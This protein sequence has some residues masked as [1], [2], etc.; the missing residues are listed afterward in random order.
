[1]KRFCFKNRKRKSQQLLEFLLIAPFLMMVLALLTEYAYALNI[2]MT[3]REG[4]R[5]VTSSIYS[6]MRPGITQDQVRSLVQY[7][8]A[9]Y[10][11]N[12]NVPIGSTGSG[13][14]MVITNPTVGYT[15]STTSANQTSA[16]TATYTYNMAFTLPN[17]YNSSGRHSMFPNSF[18]FFTTV[19]VPS[20]FLTQNN[21][22]T[23]T[24]ITSDQLD[25]IW[26]DPGSFADLDNG[27]NAG[28]DGIMRNTDAT[29]TARNRGYILF[30]VRWNEIS[31]TLTSLKG[32]AAFP[33]VALAWDGLPYHTSDNSRYYVIDVNTP[34]GALYT[35]TKSTPY[36]CSAVTGFS[37]LS[38]VRSNKPA[39]TGYSP[40]G[41]SGNSTLIFLPNN[42]T[43]ITPASAWLSGAATT[44]DISPTNVTGLLKSAI[45]ISN[46]TGASLGNYD[47][48]DVSGYNS[49]FSTGSYV[50][51]PCGSIAIFYSSKT[52][53]Y[54]FPI[55]YIS[56]LGMTNIPDYNYE[57]SDN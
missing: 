7:N 39:S 25:R 14:S 41:T 46:S 33:Y 12:N 23:T 49:S 57:F 6:E 18:T 3:L 48:L 36:N 40:Y 20:A 26:A 5:T 45:S 4:L 24:R 52:D 30:L 19:A 55:D 47:N 44:A 37:L 43:A 27:L 17:I 21:Y 32:D 9:M 56:P 34:N 22:P 1:M 28:R 29:L 42:F 38:F 35:C 10:L 50:Y 2:N 31:T 16:F 51:R 15:Y 13:A 8:L 53:D 11:Q 54:I